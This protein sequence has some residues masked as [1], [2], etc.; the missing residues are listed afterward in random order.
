MSSDKR[1]PGIRKVWLD[2][3]E[4]QA[5]NVP[6]LQADK[7]ALDY[8]RVHGITTVFTGNLNEG[9][10]PLN[11]F[12]DIYPVLNFRGKGTGLVRGVRKPRIIIASRRLMDEHPEQI[13]DGKLCFGV[14][15]YRIRMFESYRD[16]SQ[17]FKGIYFRV[18]PLVKSQDKSFVYQGTVARAVFE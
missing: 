13:G 12:Q 5:L 18:D 7:R 1:D 10:L 2:F 11:E 4:L 15:S 16:K 9:Y 8:Y 14:A 6:M 17:T 3:D